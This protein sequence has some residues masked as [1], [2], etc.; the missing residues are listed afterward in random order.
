MSL[1]VCAQDCRHQS[2]G[3][4]ALNQ[5][6]SLSSNSKAKCGY[7]EKIGTQ[8]AKDTPSTTVTSTENMEGFR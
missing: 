7:Y 3:Y 1:I 2:E 6:T 8:S 4:C 5:I